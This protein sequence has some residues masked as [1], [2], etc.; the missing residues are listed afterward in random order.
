MEAIQRRI[1]ASSSALCWVSV[2]IAMVIFLMSSAEDL[3]CSWELSHSH[4]WGPIGS[5]ATFYARVSSWE[6]QIDQ[7]IKNT[8]CRGETIQEDIEILCCRMWD[9]I[10]LGCVGKCVWG[11]GCHVPVIDHHPPMRENII[12]ELSQLPWQ[13]LVHGLCYLL[14]QAVDFPLLGDNKEKT[15]T[16]W[17]FM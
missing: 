12:F 2:M 5:V 13:R 14:D 10:A 3:G 1:H 7:I 17:E 4:R 16:S 8:Q 6:G 11:C 15:E 9:G